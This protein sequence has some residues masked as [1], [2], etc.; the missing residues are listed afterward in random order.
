M[1]IKGGNEPAKEGLKMRAIVWIFSRLFCFRW[2]PKGNQHPTPSVITH[3]HLVQQIYTPN[4]VPSTLPRQSLECLLFL[5]LLWID[6]KKSKEKSERG[7]IYNL[8]VVI[9]KVKK[10]NLHCHLKPTVQIHW[11][12]NGWCEQGVK[13]PKGEN[14]TKRKGSVGFCEEIKR[15]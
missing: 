10:L 3:T 6:R 14:E 9:Y 12:V 5:P 2:D 4:S 13:H 1:Q 7:S 15:N 8:P 11:K